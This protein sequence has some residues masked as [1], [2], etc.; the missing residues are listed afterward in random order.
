M[1]FVAVLSVI[2]FA[3]SF[4]R[5]AD[6]APRPNVII[7]LTDDQGYGDFSCHG[8]PVLKT[9][10]LDKLHDQSIRLTDFH[11]APMCTPTRG[12]LLTGMHC[13][14]NGAMNVSSGR[15]LLR[16]GIPTLANNLADGGYRCGIF[17]K[18]HLGDNYPYRPQDRGFHE[19]LWFPSSHIGSAPDFWNNHYFDDTY[20][21]NG[22]RERFQGY[23]TDV[24]FHE[25]M[26]WMLA[27]A[28]ANEPFFCYLP[29]AAPHAPLYVPDKYREP[30]RALGP[31]LASFFGM[32]ANIDENVG[33]LE[34]FLQQSGLRDD[35]ILIFM[36]D[37]GGTAG[38]NFFNAGM[39]GGKVTLYE[40]GHRVPCFIRW[41]HGNLGDP[42]DVKALTEVQDLSLTLYGLC[43]VGWR[44]AA[45]GVDLGPL[46]RGDVQ[47]L[48][49]R[50]LVVSFSRMNDPVPTKDKSAVLW[51][52]WRLLP[53]NKLFDVE[54]DP[55]QERDVA[56]DHPDVV[57]QMRKRLDAWWADVEPHVN[58]HEAVVIGNDAEN[59]SMLS[60]TEWED[61]FF[62]QGAQVRDGTRRNGVWN[63][64]VDRAG[65]YEFELRRWPRE[66][67]APIAA[68]V[69]EFKHPDGSY[70][71]GVAL[72]IVQARLKVAS[73]DG[74]IQ[75]GAQ[76]KFIRFGV[77]LPK[78]RTRLQTW[79]YDPSGDAICGAYYV[80]VKRLN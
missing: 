68:G 27:R 37:N 77:S 62:D 17:G 63:I 54:K 1:K 51:R 3:A 80:Y 74:Q 29:T 31:K 76:D 57:A 73:F 67:D 44:T 58:D 9:P 22:K 52:R 64:E 15:T 56:A 55:A 79:F 28:A 78:G 19:T 49:D 26:K 4:A 72:P 10:N 65:Q 24:F 33:Q 5:V 23:T 75:V 40:G 70:P 11:V 32:I 18:W 61:V 60:P 59:P 14:R 35:T 42:R 45:D 39:T 25:A 43:N 69:P 8:N 46:L 53:G 12:Q 30:Y 16:R 50:M 6:S 48:P 34:A 20:I 2:L 36:T 21:H 71:A 13:L 47:S 38:V 7:L 41:P 66:A